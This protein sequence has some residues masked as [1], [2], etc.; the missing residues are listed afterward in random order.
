M[1]K[2]E[3]NGRFK[4]KYTN[5]PYHCKCCQKFFKSLL[6]HLGQ[7]PKCKLEYSDKE[8]DNLKAQMQSISDTKEKSRKTEYYKTNRDSLLEKRAIY[9]EKNS[10]KIHEQ[11]Q[12][13][14]TQLK[15]KEYY[16]KNKEILA[17]N[18]DLQLLDISKQKVSEKSENQSSTS[19]DAKVKPT[20]NCINCSRTFKVQAYFLD[21]I[22]ENHPNYPDSALT[23]EQIAILEGTTTREEVY[24]LENRD[25]ILKK[26]AKRYET[27]KEWMLDRNNASYWNNRESYTETRAKYYQ[28]NKEK[29]KEHYEK[30]KEEISSKR[31]A[32]YLQ[33]KKKFYE[34]K[35]KSRLEEAIEVRMK[36]FDYS[37]LT[38]RNINRMEG[39]FFKDT[40]LKHIKR[41]QLN[42]LSAGDRQKL[43]NFEKVIT[44]K[45]KHFEKV[46]N[47]IMKDVK[48]FKKETFETIEEMYKKEDIINRK[49]HQLYKTIYRKDEPESP[50]RILKEWKEVQREV[51]RELFALSLKYNES[52]PYSPKCES[53][54]LK[55]S[56]FT[57]IH[58]NEDPDELRN[59]WI[60]YMEDA[61]EDL[62]K[63]P[64]IVR[65]YTSSTFS[66]N[67]TLG[68]KK[69]RNPVEF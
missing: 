63:G 11:R 34:D 44:S 4:Q 17:R 57:H 26:K 51:D 60:K 5:D 50:D 43:V 69:E 19:E 6:K 67:W 66:M 40:R 28:K 29:I 21:H 58:K 14:E 46:I 22:N 35:A 42:M 65:Y 55:K 10:S 48:A 39:E 54:C 18:R 47:D 68:E 9:S 61:E 49:F 27:E 37:A 1:E 62:A 2:E 3:Y 8:F 24:Y 52:L 41:L 45:Y 16:Q 56:N 64:Q 12:S 32:L 59:D 15:K 31:K 38:A 20:Y 25:K 30:N 53:E 7:Q 13:V 36:H 33:D 23:K